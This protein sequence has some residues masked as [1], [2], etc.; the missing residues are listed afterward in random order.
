MRGNRLGPRCRSRCRWSITAQA[1]AMEHRT[2]GTSCCIGDGMHA[3]DVAPSMSRP[4]STPEGSWRGTATTATPARRR[5]RTHFR[6]CGAVTG[7]SP[8][9]G[10]LF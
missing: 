2:Y 9:T 7:G 3:L 5:I 10:D 1:L 4:N 8:V 6:V